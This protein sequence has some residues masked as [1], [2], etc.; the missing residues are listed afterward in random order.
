M[1]QMMTRAAWVIEGEYPVIVVCNVVYC[2]HSPRMLSASLHADDQ[3]QRLQQLYTA[4]LHLD[5]DVLSASLSCTCMCLFVCDCHLCSHLVS[6]PIQS[7][8]RCS[9]CG[10]LLSFA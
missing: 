2:Q 4:M 8:I 1:T 3:R 7:C 5:S 6:A 9:A 10:S